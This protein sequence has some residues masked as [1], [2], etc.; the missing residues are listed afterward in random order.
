MHYFIDGYNMLFRLMP[1][2]KELQS[3]R[4]Q[5]IYDLHQKIQLVEMD[6]SIVFDA[7]FQV[8]ERSRSHYQELE[9]LFTAQG[10]TADEFIL[11]EINRSLT[12]RQETVVTS[13]K[14]LAWQVRR[15]HAHTESVEDFIARL[16]KAYK[17]RSRQQKKSKTTLSSSKPS[18]SLPVKQEPQTQPKV[19]TPLSAKTAVEEWTS[20]YEKTFE[21]RF[22]ELL[23]KEKKTPEKDNSKPAKPQNKRKKK[24]SFPDP[25]SLPPQDATTEMERWLK[26]FET[27]VKDDSSSV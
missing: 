13:D 23:Q 8:G 6:V 10:E 3:Q 9:I 11:E 12:P 7:A 20:Y 24:S 27:R 19:L 2:D 5:I 25:F 16:N 1:A 22:Q 15:C 21:Q 26:I 4:E 14:K 18:D 17:N